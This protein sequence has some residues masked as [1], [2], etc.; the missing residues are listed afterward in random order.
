MAA[1]VFV[2][3]DWAARYPELAATVTEATAEAMFM[4][5]ELL[6]LGND[7][8]DQPPSI[9]VN[10]AMRLRLFYLL[11]AHLAVLQQRSSASGGQGAGMVGNINSASEGSVSVGVTPLKSDS[12]AAAF[13]NQTQY[14]ATYWMAMRP[15]TRALYFPGPKP[16]VDYSVF[17][18]PYRR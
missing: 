4:D 18:F 16:F 7:L 2:Y 8:P 3:A 12:E 15:Y 1:V 13:F 10:E 6:Y 5:A 17:R 9:V 11:V 14:G